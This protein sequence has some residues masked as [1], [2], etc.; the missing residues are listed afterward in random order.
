VTKRRGNRKGGDGS[1][2]EIG[3]PAGGVEYGL[4]GGCFFEEG[5][6]VGSGL[7]LRRECRGLTRLLYSR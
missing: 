1:E 6:K 3:E 7:G 4:A 2:A 5:S